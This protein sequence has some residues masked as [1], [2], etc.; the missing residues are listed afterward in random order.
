M[1]CT[2]FNVL[3][4]LLPL[5]LLGVVLAI[6]GR[7]EGQ[8]SIQAAGAAARSSPARPLVGGGPRGRCAPRDYFSWV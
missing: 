8:V 2:V 3:L 1:I 7:A 6:D 5:L 4:L